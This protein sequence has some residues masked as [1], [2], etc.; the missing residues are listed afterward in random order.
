M[1]YDLCKRYPR[2]T[3]KSEVAA[4]TWLIGRAYAASLER[5]A[6]TLKDS[7]DGFYEQTVGPRLI[8]VGEDIDRL[9]SA[10][11]ITDPRIAD[12]GVREHSQVLEYVNNVTGN[13]NRSFVSKYLHFHAPD[14]FYIYDSRALEVV[15]E[16]VTAQRRESHSDGD[17]VY[18]SFVAKCY[19]ISACILKKTGLWPTPRELDTAFLLWHRNISRL[20]A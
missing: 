18:A 4:K 8:T 3:E 15:K 1:L 19:L 2:H 12:I 7:P 20:H 6:K 9:I 16:L 11:L 5:K 10:I 17:N 14:H 13:H